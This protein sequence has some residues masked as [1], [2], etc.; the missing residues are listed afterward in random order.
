MEKLYFKTDNKKNALKIAKKGD[1]WRMI[2]GKRFWKQQMQELTT[3]ERVVWIELEMYAGPKI[4]CWVGIR[5]M[6][7]DLNVS[8]NTIQKATEGLEQKKW[9]K[10]DKRRPDKWLRN[11]Y[12]LCM[13]IGLK[14]VSVS[15]T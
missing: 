1:S 6:A 4:K 13:K 8:V 7:K 9:I 11:E 14:G 2:L 12:T 10:I 5:G 3:T 15:D